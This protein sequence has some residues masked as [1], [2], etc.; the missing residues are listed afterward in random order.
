MKTYRPAGDLLASAEDVLRHPH[1]IREQAH[2]GASWAPHP[3]TYAL[4]L[5]RVLELL[6]EGRHYSWIGI[7]LVFGETA[8]RQA[9]CGPVPPC[10]SFSVGS[11]NAG[12]GERGPGH[13]TFRETKSEIMVPI[14]LAT[15]ILGVID[16]ESDHVNAFSSEDRVLLE[17][18][19]D[20]L[21]RFLAGD[22]KYIV[23]HAQE[24]WRRS[25]RS[26]ARAASK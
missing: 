9:F 23:R 8:V 20:M 21:A 22:G 26:A 15:R 16:A 12:A 24:H 18:L 11:A 17:R 4:P 25:T 2:Y 7:Y 3:P 1:N 14:K 5:E 13:S 19:A 6:Y 10:H